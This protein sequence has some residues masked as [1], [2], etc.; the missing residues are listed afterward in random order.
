MVIERQLELR[1]GETECAQQMR[2]ECIRGPVNAIRTAQLG[3]LRHLQALV[4]TRID[5]AEGLQVEIH[6]HRKTVIA[7]VP[8]NADPDAAELLL[9]DVDAGSTRPRPGLDAEVTRELDHAL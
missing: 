9:S 4:A 6:V 7:G 3:Q 8:P 2:L 1:S 5:P